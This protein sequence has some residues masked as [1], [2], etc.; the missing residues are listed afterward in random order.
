[1]PSS[2]VSQS[3]DV[4]K[5]YGPRGA[6]RRPPGQF[7]GWSGGSNTVLAAVLGTNS[8]TLSI[9]G[10]LPP[11]MAIFGSSGLYEIAAYVLAATAT[12]SISRYR[13]VGTWYKQTTEKMV[14]PKSRSVL[15]ER[16]VGVL[17]AVAILAIA[18]GWE[19]Y[20]FSLAMPATS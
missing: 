4:P 2:A 20:S 18:C 15:R 14:A 17:L 8:F 6:T 16:N 3:A 13:L 19:A 7:A 5:E 10:R 1:M 12:V 11:S 9:G